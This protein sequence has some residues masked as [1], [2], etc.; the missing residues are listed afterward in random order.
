MH[1][2]I[3]APTSSCSCGAAAFSLR[4]KPLTRFYCHCLI[5]QRLYKAPF[6]DVTV[7]WAGSE[8]LRSADEVVF[9]SYRLPPALRRGTCRACS[10][11]VLGY[12][13]IAPLLRL[14]FVPSRNIGPAATH[15]SA[16]AHIFY[17]RRV[18]DA[19]DAL[20]KF[21]GYW[22]SELAVARLV[23]RGALHGAA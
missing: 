18:A 1:A 9:R 23:L 7:F 21:S 4:A 2:L 17:H 16:A 13:R 10:A 22:S 20:P 12:L 5:C 3:D 19:S 8:R 14:V 11:P 15:P 6:A